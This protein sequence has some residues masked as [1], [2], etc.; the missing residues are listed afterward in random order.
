MR[1]FFLFAVVAST[2][3]SALRGD[4]PAATSRP[5]VRVAY[6]TTRIVEPLGADRLPDY[7]AALNQAHSKGVT[8]ENNAMVLVIEAVGLDRYK[9]E[10][11]QK[12]LKALGMKAL[13]GP[14]LDVSSEENQEIDECLK[15]DVLKVADHENVTACIERNRKPL[16]LLGWAGKR[17]R[18]YWPQPTGNP[19]GLLGN[20]MEGPLFSPSMKLVA[21]RARFSAARG[22]WQDARNDLLTLRRLGALAVGD[23]SLIEEL[24]ALSCERIANEATERIACEGKLD[25]KIALAMIADIDAAPSGSPKLEGIDVSERFLLLEEILLVSKQPREQIVRQLFDLSVMG[26]GKS[27]PVPKFEEAVYFAGLVRS[28]DWNEALQEVNRRFDSISAAMKL[29]TVPEQIKALDKADSEFNDWRAA[30]LTKFSRRPE[31]GTKEATT[32]LGDLMLSWLGDSTRSAHKSST[33]A[34]EHRELCK[35]ALGLR[36]YF[37]D[38]GQYPKKLE[39]LVPKYL[40]SVPEDIFSGKAIKFRRKGAGFIIYSIG[41]DLVDDGG[42]GSESGNEPDIVV[43]SKN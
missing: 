6:E 21:V 26:S 35:A 8:P 17:T 5:A 7:V 2:F 39:E 43:E 15:V 27:G 41:Y 36:A 24:Q 3:A 40:K 30:V 14:F 22:Q 37:A 4:E 1:T 18:W 28:S 16:E 23:T 34:M 42:N 19:L 12:T 13:E 38:Q 11:R 25:S 33:R 32:L 10:Q 31:P 29:P 20:S 9:P